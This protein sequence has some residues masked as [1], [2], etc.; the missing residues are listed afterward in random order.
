MK[1]KS[2]MYVKK[3]LPQWPIKLTYSY[4]I[5][6]ERPPPNIKDPSLPSVRVSCLYT[7]L[8]C[9]IQPDISIDAI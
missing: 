2:H 1:V 7:M 6:R 9:D 8:P 4:Y 3:N 5:Y